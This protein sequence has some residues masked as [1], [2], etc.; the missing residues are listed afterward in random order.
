MLNRC[1]GET[2][3]LDRGSP[4]SWRFVEKHGD[5]WAM[6][7]EEWQEYTERKGGVFCVLPATLIEKSRS[8]NEPKK[9]EGF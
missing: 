5:L 9:S 7:E 8:F 4:W 1:T 6:S 3:R 2:W